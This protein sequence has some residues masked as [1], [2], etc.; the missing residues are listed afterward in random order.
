AETLMLPSETL[1]LA[2]L[3]TVPRLMIGPDKSQSIGLGSSPQVQEKEA[4]RQNKKTLFI[5]DIDPKVTDHQA[6]V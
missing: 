4:V 5:D 1:Q 3:V 6:Y 2:A